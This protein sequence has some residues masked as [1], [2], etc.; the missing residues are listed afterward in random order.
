MEKIGEEIFFTPK[1]PIRIDL[2]QLNILSISDIDCV[3]VSVFRELY[4]L[5]YLILSG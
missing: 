1:F 5:P 4:G 2:K 3:L